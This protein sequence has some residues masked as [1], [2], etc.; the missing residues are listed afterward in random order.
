MKVATYIRKFRKLP[1]VVKQFANNGSYAVNEELFWDQ[2]VQEWEQSDRN[3]EQA[4]L[5][6]EWKNEEDFLSLLENYSSREKSALEIGC[7][8]GR[9]TGSGV[10]LF[11]HVYAAD[12]SEE[13]L[14]KSRQAVASTNVSFHKLDGFTLND[15]ADGTIDYVYS[16]DVFVQLSSIQV[17]PYLRE[18]KRVLKTGGIGLVSVYDFVGQFD[19]FKQWSLKFWNQRRL[20]V[21]RRL[22]FVTEEMLR[23]MLADLGLQV[24]EAQR[25]KFLTVAFR[26]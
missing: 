20:P 4:Y 18:I 21:Y 17:Y 7:G 24:L 10:K 5:G 22:H 23:V 2:Y 13:M 11:K 9:I 3:K 16:H 6:S 14:R 12:L 15:F 26:K 19:L 1:H 25:K 8:G